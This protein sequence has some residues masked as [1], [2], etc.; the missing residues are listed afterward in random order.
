MV[1]ALALVGFFWIFVAPGYAMKL[2]TL[3]GFFAAVLCPLVMDPTRRWTQAFWRCF[4]TVYA[5]AL[6]A[7]MIAE[8]RAPASFIPTI[9]SC[10]VPGLVFGTMASLGLAHS[11]LDEL[12]E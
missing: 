8:V 6:I 1:L 5:A 7:A 11:D 10:I 3:N 9:A 4:D 12:P 2:A